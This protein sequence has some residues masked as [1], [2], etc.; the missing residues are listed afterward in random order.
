MKIMKKHIA[1]STLGIGIVLLALPV[2]VF[3]QT[4]TPGQKGNKTVRLTTLN[5]NCQ[6]AVNQRVT[7]LTTVQTRIPTLKRLSSSQQQQ[8]LGQIAT[9]ISGLQKVQTQ[10]TT[11]FTSGNLPSLA[12]DYKSIFTT[13]RIYAA[14]LPQLNL[15]IAS[16]TMGYTANNLTTL[17]GKLQTRVQTAGNP[18]N[19]TALLADMNAK[20]T[21][22]QTQY[23]TVE[24]QVAGLTPASYNSNPSGTTAI[25]QTARSEIKTGAS[26]LQTA[27]SDA[28]Q[29]IQTLKTVKT[30]VSVSPSH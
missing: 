15:L 27:L 1:L 19:L 3:A 22:A 24:S 13:Y 29:I 6:N 8:F 5:T 21:D 14:M 18:S 30:T 9:N 26:D 11:D 17:Y 23:S 25:F 2:S 16:D 28:K 20:V 4:V 12:S 7:S 10:C